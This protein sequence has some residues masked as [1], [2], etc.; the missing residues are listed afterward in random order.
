[1]RLKLAIELASA[2]T[3]RFVSAGGVLAISIILSRQLALPDAG[4]F[5]EAFTVLMGL[6]ILTR[7]GQELRLLRAVAQSGKGSLHEFMASLSLVTLASIVVGMPFVLWWAH[8]GSQAPLQLVWLPLIPTAMTNVVAAYIKGVGRT[9]LGALA[10][11]GSIS[12]VA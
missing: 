6:A 9:G 10:E 5:F 11:V 4:T 1:M 3:G 7:C 2:F 12:V 8:S